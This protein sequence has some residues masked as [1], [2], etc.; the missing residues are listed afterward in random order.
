MY[1][2]ISQLSNLLIKITYIKDETAIHLITFRACTTSS[3]QKGTLLLLPLR[4]FVTSGL[5]NRS[6]R[7]FSIHSHLTPILNFI[8]PRSAL[9]SSSHL[10]LGLPVLTTIGLHS[11]TLFTVLPLSILTTCQKVTLE[12]TYSGLFSHF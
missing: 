11:V 4:L 7:R 2:Y 1:T 3:S 8:F 12:C 10:N 9:T 5:L 6:L